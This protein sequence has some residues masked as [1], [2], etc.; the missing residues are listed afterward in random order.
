MPGT[1][2]GK[3]LKYINSLKCVVLTQIR[4]NHVMFW[5]NLCADAVNATYT[6]RTVV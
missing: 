3:H 5:S 4:Y 6:I 2:A 1:L